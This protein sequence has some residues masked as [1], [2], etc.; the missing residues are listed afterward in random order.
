M[1]TIGRWSPN[2]VR[3]RVLDGT[4]VAPEVLGGMVLVTPTS[5]SY[6]S[7]SA[8][9]NTN[10][11][12]TVVDPTEVTINGI[13]SSEYDNYVII[14]KHNNTDYQGSSGYF[15]SSGVPD[16]TSNSYTRQYLNATGADIYAGRASA[17]FMNQFLVT[18]GSRGGDV[19]YV[20]GPYLAQPTAV[21]SAGASDWQSAEIYDRAYTHNVSQSFDG[22]KLVTYGSFDLAVYGLVGA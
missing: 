18:A 21:R 22:I 9:I 16:S 14:C 2:K 1:T 8:T 19:L 17:S 13:F 7:G 11:S 3:A 10:G 6:L 20:Y 12:I 5:V 15:T 4:W